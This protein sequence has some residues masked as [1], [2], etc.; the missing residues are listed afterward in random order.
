MD[1]FAVIGKRLPLLDAPD[2]AT[3]RATYVA[4][5]VLPGMLQGLILRSPYPHARIVNVDTSRALRLHGVKAVITGKETRGK[6]YGVM[7]QTADE[8]AIAVD[9]VNYIG[10]AVAAV[11]AVDSD[12]AG[13][14]LDLI[15]VDYEQLP[16]VH[17][18]S[19]A[20]KEGAPL[21]HADSPGNVACQVSWTFG[22]MAEGFRQ[23]E[24]VRE[25]VFETQP[26]THAPM[27]PHGTVASFDQSSGILTVWAST[28]N[29]HLCRLSLSM[30]L[31]IPESR[32]HIIKPTVGGGFGGK[33]EMYAHDFAAALLSMKTGRPVRVICS[34]DEVFSATRYRQPMRV[35]LRT[36]VKKDG[37]LL[38]RDCRII[39]DGGACTSTGLGTLYLA[40]M[41]PNLPYRLP[42][43]RYDG[44]RVYTNKTPAGPQRG[45]GAVQGTFAVESQMDMIARD[46]GLDPVEIRMR[47]AASAGYETANNVKL[48]SCSMSECVEKA[49]EIIGWTDGDNARGH[50]RGMAAGSFTSGQQIV[51]HLR[52]SAFI[53]IHYDGAIILFT[54]APDVG[55]GSNTVLAQIAAEELGVRLEDIRVIAADS[56]LTPMDSGAYSSRVTTF[57]GNAVK[58]A[59]ARARSQL[60]EVAAL[61]L[62]ARPED[63]QAMGGRIWVKGSPD[64][65]LAYQQVAKAYL[66]EKEEPIVAHG[67]FYQ[68]E[69][70][71]NVGTGSFRTARGILPPGN[72]LEKP[73][74]SFSFAAQVAEVQVDRETGVVSV[75][76]YAASHDSGR[77]LNPMAVEGQIEGSI[78][79]GLGQAL[80]EGLDRHEGQ[81]YNPSFLDYKLP[82]ALE[83]PTCQVWEADTP[84]P[85]GPFGAKESGEGTQVPGPATI[86]NAVFDA[87]GVRITELPITP[88]KVLE[89]LEE[90]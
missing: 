15:R 76:R 7:P 84:D 9:K 59:A 31:G 78:A 40:G 33:V 64:R 87:A 68:Q 90:A 27:E 81:A 62:E 47:N 39:S 22:N 53:K 1:G 36:G 26:V 45:H 44:I 70:H 37:K 57:V 50:G 41:I 42:A 54:G 29:L 51:P 30:T 19:E 58:D 69:D 89:A 5:I 83:M 21:I 17:S 11:A 34:R 66:R 12:A 71:S 79:G 63:L 86:A 25:D 35:W 67:S 75:L 24:H 49:A 6:R 43:F 38:A 56:D 82:T 16:A 77:A 28:Q 74:P 65:G 46:L 23:A 3:G 88:E 20:M 85:I 32:I 4:D 14:A 80:M 13:Q 8:L 48:N 61:E 55:Q 2:K 72:T 10:E 60:F 18:A 73:A 52:A